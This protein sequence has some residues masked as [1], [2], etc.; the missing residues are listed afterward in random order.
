[1]QIPPLVNQIP[2][3]LLN[4]IGCHAAKSGNIRHCVENHWKINQEL[5]ELRT[6]EYSRLTLSYLINS[7]S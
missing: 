1:M 2:I 7:P 4:L 3:Y 6:D 5:V